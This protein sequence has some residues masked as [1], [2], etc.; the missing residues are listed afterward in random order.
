LDEDL[1][2]VSRQ[3]NDSSGLVLG[4]LSSGRNLTFTGRFGLA[5][6]HKEALA[7]YDSIFHQ[8]L[9]HQAGTHPQVYSQSL[10]GIVLFCLGFP[11]QALARSEAAIAEARKLA[12]PPSLAASLTSG[13]TALSL[14]GDKAALDDRADQLIAVATEHGFPYWRAWGT[15]YCGWVKVNNGNLAE[16]ISL[17]RSGSAA[18]RATG[19]ALWVPYHTALLARADEIAGQIEE[20]LTLLDEAL[21]IVERTGDGGSLR[22]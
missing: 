5:R 12:H 15:I 10:L 22:S 7:L 2:E 6:S 1:L 3:R 9:V 20:S 11:K 14:V 13:S 18:Y 19:A 21:Q 16:G 17:L 8:S 4:H